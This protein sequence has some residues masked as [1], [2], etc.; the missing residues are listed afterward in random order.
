MCSLDLFG[1]YLTSS[2]LQFGFKM[3]IGYRDATYALHSAVDFYTEQWS[4]VNM[5]LLDMSKAFHKSLW[6]VHKIN[7][8]IF[9]A[10][11]FLQISWYSKCCVYVR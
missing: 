3:K 10:D 7:G 2:D 6:F 9:A 8:K 4:T 1:K 5:G 11:F